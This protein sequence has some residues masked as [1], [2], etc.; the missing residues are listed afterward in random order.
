MKLIAIASLIPDAII[1]LRY[2]SDDNITGHRLYEVGTEPMLDEPAARQLTR[3]AAILRDQSL[4]LVIWDAYRPLR[5]Q[6]QLRAVNDDER[7]VLAVSNHCKGLAIDVTLA[8][9]DGTYLAMGGDFDD[10]SERAYVNASGLYP[11]ELAHRK[12]L[13][14]A[15]SQA[16]FKV[17]L[18]EWWHFDF[19]G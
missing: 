7:Y 17:W 3:A 6:A 9:K 15:M 2:A 18:Y 5:V 1:D 12:Q 8:D 13:Q 14:A 16:G 4:R 19:E 11:E 10:F